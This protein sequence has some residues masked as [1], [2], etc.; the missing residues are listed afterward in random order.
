MSEGPWAVELAVTTRDVLASLRQ[1]DAGPVAER[2]ATAEELYGATGEDLLPFVVDLAA[3]AR[4]A[5]DADDRLY[6]W[7]CV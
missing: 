7:T 2:W 1:E 6:C 3:L 5:A 4:R